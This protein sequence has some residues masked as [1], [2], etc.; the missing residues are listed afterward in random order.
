MKME[1]YFACA[2][3]FKSVEGQLAKTEGACPK[4]G[5]RTAQNKAKFDKQSTEMTDNHKKSRGELNA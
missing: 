2:C 3:G 4:C 1:N 5:R